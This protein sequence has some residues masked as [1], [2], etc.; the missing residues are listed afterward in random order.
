LAAC[1]SANISSRNSGE[2]A[3][4]NPVFS[5]FRYEG[6]DAVYKENPLASDEFYSPILQDVIRIPVLPVKGRITIW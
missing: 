3:G 4:E 1:Q 5:D 6:K 2:N